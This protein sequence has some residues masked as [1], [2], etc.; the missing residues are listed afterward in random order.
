MAAEYDL[1]EAQVEVEVEKRL[2]D[3]VKNDPN[4]V[5]SAYQKALTVA[6]EKIAI[7]APKVRKYDEFLDT[8]GYL[9]SAE[10]SDA[11]VKIEYI[12]PDGK[13]RRMGRNYLLQ[14]LAIDGLIMQTSSG[15]MIPSSK[16]SMLEGAGRAVTKTTAVNDRM[17][18]VVLWTAIGIDWLKDR[19]DKDY[20]IWHSDSEHNLYFE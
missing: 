19:Y 16:R 14:V 9:N 6:N 2:K 1:F 18:T 10:I 12:A 13:V 20:R 11:V 4:I 5:I 3:L 8:D 15:Y 17:R 7:D